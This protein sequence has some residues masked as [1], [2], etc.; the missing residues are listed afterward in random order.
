MGKRICLVQLRE[1]YVFTTKTTVSFKAAGFKYEYVIR[2]TNL[3][4]I[5]S[6]AGNSVA[7]D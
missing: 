5:L 2:L 4:D 6:L 1:A 7:R 3:G